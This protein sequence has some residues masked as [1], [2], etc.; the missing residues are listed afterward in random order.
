MHFKWL[1]LSHF[2]AC[3]KMVLWGIECRKSGCAN[4]S[5]N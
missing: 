1:R 5:E 2:R 4:V 3:A